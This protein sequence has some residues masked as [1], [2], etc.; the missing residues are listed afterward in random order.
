PLLIG[1]DPKCQVHLDVSVV[2]RR[3]AEV[4]WTDDGWVL[5]DLGSSNGTFVGGRQVQVVPVGAGVEVRLGNAAD[6]P[7]LRLGPTDDTATA[8]LAPAPPVSAPPAP[9]LPTPAPVAR[10]VAA[11]AGRTPMAAHAAT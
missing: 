3:H 9:A 5:R 2:S 4:A 7:V 6:G 1:R 10:G 8:K 11:V